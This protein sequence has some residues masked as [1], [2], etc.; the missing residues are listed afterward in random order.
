MSVLHILP[1]AGSPSFES[2]CCTNC[3]AA[4][5]TAII[6]AVASALVTSCHADAT[7]KPSP[8]RGASSATG[9]GGVVSGWMTR[10][11][12]VATAMSAEAPSA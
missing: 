8:S 11:S 3:E 6:T 10:S 5:V 7:T 4:Y 1:L 2:P 9:A 12:T